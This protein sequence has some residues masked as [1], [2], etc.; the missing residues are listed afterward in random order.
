MNPDDEIREEI[1]SHLRQREQW[2]AQ[3]GIPDARTEAR[4]RFGNTAQIHEETRRMHIPL[5]VEQSF[6]NITL[7]WR[8]FRRT[9]GFTLTALLTIAIGIGAGSAVFSVV[10]RILFRP[11]AYRDEARLVWLGMRA[12]IMADNEFV[13]AADYSAWQKEQTVFDALTS[14]QAAQDCTLL[15]SGAI[16]IRCARLEWNFLPALGLELQWGSG[17]TRED[18][19]PGVPP[20][21]MISAGLWKDKFG[22]RVD[23]VGQSVTVDGQPVRIVGVLPE[24]FEL[25]N[26]Q[27]VDIVR[28]QQINWAGQVRGKSTIII[29]AFARLKPGVTIQA[30]QAAMQPLFV[31]ALRFVPERF[32]KEVTLEVHSLRERQ[33]RDSLR[34]S[35]LLLGAVVCLLLITCLNVA[36]LLIARAAG[37]RQEMVIRK[38]L[39]AG[40]GALLAQQLTESLMLGLGGGLLGIGLGALLLQAFV[41]IAPAGIPR[42]D[43]ATLDLR[44]VGFS[45]AA[46]LLAGLVVGLF[47][48][49]RALRPESLGGRKATAPVR[50]TLVAL[51]LACSIILLAGAGLLAQT[52]FRLQAVRLGFAPAGLMTASLQLDPTR[53]T[54]LEPCLQFYGALEQALRAIPGLNA[55]TVSDSLPPAGSALA[56][57]YS[58]IGVEG[59]P[60]I[61]EG[62]G[63]MVT[64]RNVSAGYFAALGIPI[65]RGRAFEENDPQAADSI[66]LSESL[67]ARM[68]PGE[69]PLQKRIRPGGQQW[70][71]VIGIA[72]DVRNAGLRSAPDPE[73]YTTLAA[74][75][76]PLRSAQVTLRLPSMQPEAA[77]RARQVVA[78]EVARLDPNVPVALEPV[79]RRVERLTAPARFQAALL[80][81]FAAAG[82]LL[83][84]VGLYGLLSLLV[85]SRTREIGVRMA[86]GARSAD[87]AGMVIWQAARWTGAGVLLGLLGTWGA[88]LWL[89][90]LLY[91]VQARDAQ[92]LGVVAVLLVC[93]ALL[94]AW[95]PARRAARVDPSVALRA[96]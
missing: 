12:P 34:A 47:P 52:L 28:P 54:N 87:I 3:R 94:S 70:K 23:I 60:P 76:F 33:T 91:G 61:P 18:D 11:L 96:E 10:D 13:L 75:Q 9:P 41:A 4:R 16:K 21:V 27:R 46:A 80:S 78:E 93:V 17:F 66:I 65:V 2:L 74:R 95:L 58:N 85:A 8:S 48:A 36:N 19:R 15:M 37:R 22:G 20:T 1:E 81:L 71:T 26:M 56:M 44:V 62:T 5:A 35:V 51:Q 88:A 38:A 86:I 79:E 92:T 53:Y 42:L 83:A 57:I 72:A 77:I 40:R 39:G 59:R 14:M 30:A 29:H 49:L 69:D 45:F 89:E 63:G 31:E 68:F 43:Q 7:A 55:V 84:A 90:S 24:A 73:S 6:R 25:P 32:R 50:Q 82:L 67:A 64:H